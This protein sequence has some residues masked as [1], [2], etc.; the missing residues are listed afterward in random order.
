MKKK[1]KIR[2]EHDDAEK[3]ADHCASEAKL[4]KPDDRTH[5]DRTE[6]QRE[7]RSKPHMML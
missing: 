2:K 7:V 4:V 1:H 5:G 3:R 6:S